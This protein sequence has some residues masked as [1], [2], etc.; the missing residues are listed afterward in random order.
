MIQSDLQEFMWQQKYKDYPF[1]SIISEI[2]AVNAQKKAIFRA[3]HLAK[4]HLAFFYYL[5]YI[6]VILSVLAVLLI[7]YIY[8]YSKMMSTISNFYFSIARP[9]C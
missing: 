3:T 9:Y 7:K 5:F 4:H 8:S 1:E 2:W 6:I